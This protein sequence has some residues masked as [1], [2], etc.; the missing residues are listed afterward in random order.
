MSVIF[1]SHPNCA[2]HNMGDQHPECPSRLHAISDQLI[3]SGLDMSLIH[4]DAKPATNKDLERVHTHQHVTHLN[5]L[6]Q[7]HADR[8]DELIEIDQDTS[9][10]EHTLEAAYYA[11]GAGI[12]AVDQVMRSHLN[13][14]FCSVRPAGHHAEHDR[15]MGFCL[16]N[17]IA[18][19]AAYAMEKYE[20]KRVAIVDF[21]VH[22][23]NG[24]EDIFKD[25]PRVFFCSCFQ[26]PLYPYCGEPVNTDHI[27]NIPLSASSNAESFREAITTQCLP[28]LDQHKP[29]L[30]FISAGFDAH[31]EDPLANMGLRE[32]D[33]RWVTQSIKAVADRYAEGRIVSMLEGGYDL[34]A[35][36]RSVVAHIK[37]LL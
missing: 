27:M 5:E 18:V 33:Y 24:T 28:A 1:I 22:H 31:Y 25:D 34:S 26:H 4:M 9:M 29:E 6:G 21:D 14:A 30:I 35:L 3:A 23:G 7:E 11:A 19:A 36:G 20:L 15:A 8:P 17:N 12:L 37:G 10:S 2:L 32:E 16:F 13:T